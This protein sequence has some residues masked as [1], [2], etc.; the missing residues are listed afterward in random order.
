MMTIEISVTGRELDRAAEHEL[1]ERVLAALTGYDSAPE[2]TM[3]KAREFT[4]VLVHQPRTWVTG[5]PAPAGAPR[6]LVRL[7]V[8]GSWSGDPDFGHNI[9]PLITE[10]IAGTE[11]DPQRLRRAPHCVVQLVGL[12]ENCVGTLGR[13]T[14]STE[15][16]R[17]MT[18]DFRESGVRP[19]APDG[20][21]VDPTCGMQVEW[22]TAQ[23]TYTH[24]G[25]DYAFCAP[26][27]RKIFV[28]DHVRS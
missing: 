1:A 2:A 3:A 18:E 10:A 19:A 24:D 26:S 22:A 11:P 20:F 27:C 5:G 15:L 12:R 9:I 25:V 6:Y 13:A 16:T 4:H 14:T 21:T 28:E 23:F 17:L 7:T 8:P